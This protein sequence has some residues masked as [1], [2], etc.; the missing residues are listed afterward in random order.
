MGATE[1]GAAPLV[2][3]L[4]DAA[5]ARWRAEQ[6][7]YNGTTL[8]VLE[9]SDALRTQAWVQVDVL[10]DVRGLTILH[11]GW[12]SWSEGTSSEH[13]R[14]PGWNPQRGWQFAFG[15]SASPMWTT[16]YLWMDNL[17]VWS[18]WLVDGP[19]PFDLQARW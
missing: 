5:W 3:S 1:R 19:V 17:M 14:I 2:R 13:I 9:V 7:T 6:V 15:S 16:S 4:C 12:S 8:R 18:T 11:D 10:Y